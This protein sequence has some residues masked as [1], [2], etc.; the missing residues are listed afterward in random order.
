MFARHYTHVI[1]FRFNEKTYNTGPLMILY[2]YKL[3]CSAFHKLWLDED[4]SDK[5]DT[6]SSV[7]VLR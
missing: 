3:I 6:F 2:P 7:R 1:Y 5:Y 4:H